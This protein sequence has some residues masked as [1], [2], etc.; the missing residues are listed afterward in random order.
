MTSKQPILENEIRG[1]VLTTIRSATPNE[2]HLG[3][4]VLWLEIADS[5]PDAREGE[6]EVHPS[7]PTE[8]RRLPRAQATHL[9]ELGGEQEAGL[10]IERPGHQSPA[11]EVICPIFDRHV[12]LPGG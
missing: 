12:M 6:K 4:N 11:D 5:H 8:L 2:L 3:L 10:F 7:F 9:I 1:P